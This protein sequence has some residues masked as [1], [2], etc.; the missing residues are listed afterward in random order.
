MSLSLT[1]IIALRRLAGVY[2]RIL[3]LA[4]P[5]A[6]A[7]C[8]NGD[9]ALAPDATDAT[10]E[11]SAPVAEAPAVENLLATDL[12]RIAFV[13]YVAPGGADIWSM[14]PAGGSLTHMTSFTGAEIRPV[15]SPDHK[16]I[17][18]GRGRNGW[19][20]VYMMNTDGSYKHW[21]R[22][23]ASANII[24]EASW[25]PDGSNVLVQ[26][27]VNNN[28]YVA[29]IG[30]DNQQL[31]VVAPAGAVSLQGRYPI[32]AKDGKSI[33]YVDWAHSQIRRFVP[34]GQDVLVYSFGNTMVV[35]DL[36]LSPDGT[37]LALFMNP[38]NN[39]DIYVLNLTTLA[40]KRLTT[41]SHADTQPAWSPDGTKLAF[42]SNRSGKPQIY[43]MN[44]STGG[45]VV[46]ITSKTNGADHPSWY[47]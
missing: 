34:G 37:K 40:L 12:S 4:V 33:Y 25:A 46:K 8:Q 43:T 24:D 28:S 35:G 42:T 41:D 6:L 14:G 15:W 18:F 31:S 27:W 5:V 2:R 17:A 36:A 9:N 10:T 21:A 26:L 11:V 1:E 19:Q 13:T 20:D 29:K 39:W 32:Y 3:V 38:S 7:G 44:S 30:Y 45:N 47:R 23:I 16:H 22:T